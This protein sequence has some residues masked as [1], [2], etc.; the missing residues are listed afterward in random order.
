MSADFERRLQDLEIKVNQQ[1]FIR[2]EERPPVG[3]AAYEHEQA[4]KKKK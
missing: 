1:A 4:D 3:H 2:S